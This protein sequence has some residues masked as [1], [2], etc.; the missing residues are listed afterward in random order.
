M[1]TLKATWVRAGRVF[2]AWAWRAF[3]AYLLAGVVVAVFLLA[4][5]R[6]E[7]A[8]LEGVLGTVLGIALGGAAGVWAMRSVLR[9]DF[10]DFRIAL[11]ETFDRQRLRELEAREAD[12]GKDA[13][14]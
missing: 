5:G 7:S 14:S 2:V 1:E 10:G 4:I 3:L 13:P 9:R 8:W 6:T 12:G 11:V